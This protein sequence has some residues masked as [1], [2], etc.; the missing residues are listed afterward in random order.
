[1]AN[2][3]NSAQ[4]EPKKSYQYTV[5]MGEIAEPFLIKAAKLPS[6]EIGKIEAD[7]TQY[8]FYYPGKITW[9]PVEFTIYDVVGASSVAKKLVDLFKKAGVREPK[10]ADAGKATFSKNTLSKSLGSVIISQMDTN[11]VEIGKWT[12]TNAFIT[13]VDFGQHSYSDEGLIEV[14]VTIQYDWAAYTPNK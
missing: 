11:G 3:W 8:K 10:T 5:T 13:S 1:M 14:A 2:F 4:L 7:Y 12:L 6:M 9:T